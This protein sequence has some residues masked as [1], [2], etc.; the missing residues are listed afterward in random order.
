MT[1]KKVNSLGQ[2]VGI[3]N[4]GSWKR[5]FIFDSITLK[6]ITPQVSRPLMT[7]VRLLP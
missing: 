5:G 2:V 7:I 3:A 4:D 6:E 1:V